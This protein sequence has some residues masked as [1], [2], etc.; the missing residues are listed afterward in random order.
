MFLFGGN[1]TSFI[2]SSLNSTQSADLSSLATATFNDQ[3]VVAFYPN[4]AVDK[5]TL[6]S[7]VKSAI[8]YTFE[9]KQIDIAIRNNEIEVSHLSK[10]IYLIQGIN[11][12]GSRFSDKLVK[13]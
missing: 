7:D 5:I 9:G 8:L 13:N 2:S 4:P 12:D 6:N 1:T 3:K 10:G 11:K